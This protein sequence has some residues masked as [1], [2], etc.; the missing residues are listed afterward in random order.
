MVAT[1]AV[2]AIGCKGRRGGGTFFSTQQC[3][4]V[5]SKAC[6]QGKALLRLTPRIRRV[7]WHLAGQFGI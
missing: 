6:L 3:Q 1:T 5:R 7:F 4:Q 2:S